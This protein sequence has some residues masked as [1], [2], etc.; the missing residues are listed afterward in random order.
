MPQTN[1][2]LMFTSRNQNEAIWPSR[3][4]TKTFSCAKSKR[5]FVFLVN[6]RQG[7]MPPKN[8]GKGGGAKGS[9]NKGMR[10]I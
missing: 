6:T 4:G 8:K 7:K 5:I 10:L 1:P 2:F 3:I 9:G